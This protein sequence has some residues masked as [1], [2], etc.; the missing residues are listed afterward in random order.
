MVVQKQASADCNKSAFHHFFNIAGSDINMSANVQDIKNKEVAPE[1]M[2]HAS[3]MKHF[4]HV[5][6]NVPSL[7]SQKNG[8]TGTFYLIT[9]I[10]LHTDHFASWD[11]VQHLLIFQFSM[12][13]CPRIVI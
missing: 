9:Y 7:L 3:A 10:T 6:S 4:S 12:N 1:Q 8:T 13:L 11:P 2:C 5:V